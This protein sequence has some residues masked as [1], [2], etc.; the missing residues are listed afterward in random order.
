MSADTKRIKWE[1]ERDRKE[2]AKGE[3][4][5]TQMHHLETDSETYRKGY[6]RTPKPLRAPKPRREP[7]ERATPIKLEDA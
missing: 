7:G 6:I 2:R 3:K 5:W 4:P 1:I